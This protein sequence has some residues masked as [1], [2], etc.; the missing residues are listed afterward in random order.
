MTRHSKKTIDQRGDKFDVT[1]V[2]LNLLGNAFRS[3]VP[4]DRPPTIADIR[5]ARVS[6]QIARGELRG[7]YEG[8]SSRRRLIPPKRMRSI[9]R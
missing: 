4:T 5:S 7:Y 6:I 2:V 3:L 8:S 1:T 9:S